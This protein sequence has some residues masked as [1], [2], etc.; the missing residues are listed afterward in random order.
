[1]Q[2]IKTPGCHLPASQLAW[3]PGH[4]EEEEEE[5]ARRE[6]GW[7]S[8][9]PRGAGQGQAVTSKLWGGKRGFLMAPGP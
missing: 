3:F 8:A 2:A 1:M 5:D 7:S 4:G 9:L 6:E